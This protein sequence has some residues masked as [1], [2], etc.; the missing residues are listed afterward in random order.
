MQQATAVAARALAGGALQPIRTHEATV[1]DRGLPF[2]VRVVDSLARK[3]AARREPQA[4]PNPFLPY[5]PALFVAELSGRYV[6]LLNKYPVIEGHLLIVTR[7]FEEQETSLSGEDFAA[8]CHCLAQ[9]DGLGFYNAGLA[10]GASQRHKHL[11]LVPQPALGELPLEPEIRA[12]LEI[13]ALATALP[14]RHALAPLDPNWLD[15]PAAAGPRLAQIY[16]RLLAV[17]GR[18]GDRGY[19]GYNLLI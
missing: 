1:T 17:V 9:M 13:G 16:E 14:F 7:N 4:R 6:V 2:R 18:G 5:D 12:A 15:D 3:A 10:A 11:Q 8:L 19:G